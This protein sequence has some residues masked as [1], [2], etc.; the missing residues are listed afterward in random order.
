MVS[1]SKRER[2]QSDTEDVVVVVEQERKA[3]RSFLEIRVV[4]VALKKVSCVN[5]PIETK[6]CLPFFVSL[7]RVCYY[8]GFRL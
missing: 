3:F 7:F 5:N 8:L 4:K 1:R 2:Q 6:K